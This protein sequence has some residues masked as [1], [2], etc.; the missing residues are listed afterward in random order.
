[1]QMIEDDIS[2][3]FRDRLSVLIGDTIS[4]CE[5]ANLKP[6]DISGL[7]FSGLMWQVIKLASTIKMTEDE[8]LAVTSLAYRDMMPQLRKMLKEDARASRT[9][10]K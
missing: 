3:H 5:I 4:T 2:R 10:Q 7:V 1:M 9:A 8:L 6:I